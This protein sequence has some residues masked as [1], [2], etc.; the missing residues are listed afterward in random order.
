MPSTTASTLDPPNQNAAADERNAMGANAE[1][2]GVPRPQ[3]KALVQHQARALGDP[4]RFEIFRYV[5]EA[6]APVRIATLTEHFSFN[7]SAIRQHLAKLVEARLLIEE[8]ATVARTGRPP[9]Q[10]RLAPSA[11]GTWGA[12]SP[13][14][15]LALMLLDMAGGERT[16]VEVGA[17]AGRRM[18][19]TH[20][21][22]ADP[23]DVV[24]SEMAR[25]GFE[26]RRRLDP[27]LVEL[28]LDRCPFQAAASADPEVV[29]EIH[30]GL[31]EGILEAMGADLTVSR[32]IAHDPKRAGCR[33]QMTAGTPRP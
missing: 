25:R 16:A 30:R 8:L 26:P 20:L 12:T 1:R 22:S 24:E 19:A 2:S 29:C 18:V 32:L 13:Y 17:A 7:Q 11:M 21:P 6:P 5:A 3:M 27:P 33:L 23:L 14:E 4:T 15:L 28:V 10:Y 9:L 31:A